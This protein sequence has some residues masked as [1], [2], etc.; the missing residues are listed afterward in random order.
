[1]Q[2]RLEGEPQRI[3]RNERLTQGSQIME[4]WIKNEWIIESTDPTN[5]VKSTWETR[6]NKSGAERT[7]ILP[8][9]TKRII[10]DN[11][12]TLHE[13]RIETPA[14]RLSL[15]L[16]QTERGREFNVDFLFPEAERTDTYIFAAYAESGWLK[17]IKVR[18][19]TQSR[20]GQGIEL[21]SEEDQVEYYKTQPFEQNVQQLAQIMRLREAQSAVDVDIFDLRDV[22][23]LNLSMM[24]A[25]TTRWLGSLPPEE[26]S[27]VE[28]SMEYA[29]EVI[30]TRVDTILTDSY[31]EKEKSNIASWLG[32]Y[33][34]AYI[35]DVG[36]VVAITDDVF[37]Q[38][39]NDAVVSFIVD[40]HTRTLAA[41]NLNLVIEFD[42]DAD[43]ENFFYKVLES[44]ESITTDSRNLG[45]PFTYG[46]DR[47]CVERVADEKQ[48][49]F[50][51]YNLLPGGTRKVR[52]LPKYI[53]PEIMDQFGEIA[54]TKSN[55]GWEQ[56]I[57][58]INISSS[59]LNVKT[60]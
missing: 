9:G 48:F 2:Y 53:S 7:D 6:T 23:E 56:A 35:H 41:S 12:G 45:E 50:S 46:E 40:Y 54:G 1:M 5:G 47:F 60:R 36:D 21:A 58:L 11:I 29:R 13:V 25:G 49:Q 16:S 32:G 18:T 24:K 28:A 37:N 39:L 38:M 55:Q 52:D 34:L 42:P 15:S 44:R 27:Q 17:S 26:K 20:H 57:S 10:A 8:D 4:E 22:T 33:V 43:S 31:T 19:F 59:G 14:R 3:R 30:E 51:I